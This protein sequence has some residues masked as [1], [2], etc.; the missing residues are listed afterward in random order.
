MLRRS[1]V[2]NLVFIHGRSQEHKNPE[3]LKEAWVNALRLGLDK[4]G[5]SLALD[6]TRI[7][8][9]F[10]G[11][12]LISLIGN[13]PENAPD[14]VIKGQGNASEGE[15]RFAETLISEVAEGLSIT[16]D[17]IRQFD[18]SD[19][20]EKGFLN[21]RWT[22]ATMKAIS[23]MGGGGLAI[24]LFTHDVY[25]YLFSTG[26]RD[27]IENGVLESIRPKEPTVVV[28][29]S[30]GT[31]VSY[32]LLK[33]EGVNRQWNIRTHITLGSPLAIPTIKRSLSPI[34]FPQCVRTWMN[35]RDPRDMVALYPLVPPKFP[36]ESIT[37]NSAVTN[38]TNNRHGIEGY[39]QD[40]V[41]AKWIFEALSQ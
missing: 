29:H 39:L 40:P 16:D 14:V 30:L 15:K 34:S 31:I 17:Q 28:S 6:E 38:N 35:A 26:V 13:H 37:N 11:D 1:G 27:G 33:R 3:A 10:Y 2:H 5:L 22:L 4:A 23:S 8:F 24:S 20:V 9:P 19:I 21:S 36:V 12:M 41:V 18:Q 7:R 25:R 32:N